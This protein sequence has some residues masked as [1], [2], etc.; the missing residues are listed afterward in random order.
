MSFMSDTKLNKEQDLDAW[1]LLQKDVDLLRSRQAKRN[2]RRREK[3]KKKAVQRNGLFFMTVPKLRRKPLDLQIPS[4]DASLQSIYRRVV[5]LDASHILQPKQRKLQPWIFYNTTYPGRI[6]D[7]PD[8]T[9]SQTVV[10]ESDQNCIPMAEW[11]STFHPTCNSVHGI[12]VSNSLHQSAFKLVSSK[13]FWRNAWRVNVTS[14][15]VMGSEKVVTNTTNEFIVLKS[16]KY[17]HEPN[18]ETFELSRVDAVSLEHLTKSKF[19]INIYG[20]CGTSSLQEFASGDL[21][22]LLPILEPKEKLK[23]AMWVAEGVA[24]VHAVDYVKPRTN[25][26]ENITRVPTLI[27]N[28]INMDNVLLGRRDG[29]EVPL[30]NDYN[31]A[32]FRKKDA[33]TNKPCPFRGRFANPQWMSPEQQERSEDELS[34]GY[35]N[36]KIDVYALGNI[37]YKIAVGNSP[38][39]ADYKTS[40]I[41]PHLK[42]KIARAK[43]RGAKPKVPLEI[44]NTTDASILAVLNAMDWCYRNDPNLR[45]SAAAI[46]DGLR[47]ALLELEAAEEDS[48]VRF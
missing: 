45:P 14:D 37:L 36:E 22:G 7:E 8:M 20:F 31:I 1:T 32:V 28:D 5:P 41:T 10:Y 15:E 9:R 17:V 39:K 43:L 29:V 23:M 16:L 25:S 2:S 6:Q 13:G 30:L 40:K 44:R 21:K 33:K 18:D 48:T 24:D 3:P 26:E 35:L 42:G 4:I 27:H 12:D 38:W 11:Q 47:A 46:A 34:T 19:T